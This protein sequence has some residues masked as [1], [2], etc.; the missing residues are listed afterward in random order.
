MKRQ[1]GAAVDLEN[2][3]R[4]CLTGT[5]EELEHLLVHEQANPNEFRGPFKDDGS[6]LILVCL[7]GHGGNP[8]GHGS[9]T[10]DMA[11]LLLEHG[12]SARSI[13]Y[14]GDT[15]LHC[16]CL[17]S[18]LEVVKLLIDHGA[19][20]D[21][22]N[23]DKTSPISYTLSDHPD[24][25]ET[26]RIVSHLATVC[27]AHV[28][29]DDLDN[30]LRQYD[31]RCLEMMLNHPGTKAAADAGRLFE[32]VSG[33]RN[34][35]NKLRVLLATFPN[36]DITGDMIEYAFKASAANMELLIPRYG[37]EAR[38]DL[39]DE[40]LL[41]SFFQ[42]DVMERIAL[43]VQGGFLKRAKMRTVFTYSESPDT[44]WCRLRLAKG[45]GFEM[46]VSPKT[47][48]T[49][50]YWLGSHFHSEQFVS[51]Q[52]DTLLHRASV[53]NTAALRVL[54][55]HDINPHLRNDAG[56]LALDLVPEADKEARAFLL[57]YMQWRPT[58]TVTDWFGPYFV[59]R[60]RAFLCVCVRLDAKGELIQRDVR[61]KIVRYMA[62]NECVSI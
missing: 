9:A 4:V 55:K 27:N 21:A 50:W 6:P 51:Y 13:D 57:T 26:F 29:A 19:Y 37:E 40:T 7:R 10:L 1:I 18:T 35:A 30:A 22:L 52:N 41:D 39:L 58:R 60:A 28:S 2:Y 47:P 43:A 17:W 8:G 31:S 16:A 44:T 25:D 53:H 5:K 36:E 33:I 20:V 45:Q 32:S 54:A 11:R 38:E 14:M 62:A 59:S 42:G 48:L 49:K 46:M 56:K 24:V 12:A 34:G 3:S 23:E 15:A 61:H